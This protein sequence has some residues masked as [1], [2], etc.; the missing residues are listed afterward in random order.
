MLP[1][2]SVVIPYQF[3]TGAVVFQLVLRV[4]FGPSVAV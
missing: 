1:L 2:V 4:Q 3:L